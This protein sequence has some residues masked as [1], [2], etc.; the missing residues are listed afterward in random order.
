MCLD[1]KKMEAFAS[2][3]CW[4]EETGFIPPLHSHSIGIG[5]NTD[6]GQWPIPLRSKFSKELESLWDPYL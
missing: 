5:M 1:V 4:G 3:S 2:H 6:D